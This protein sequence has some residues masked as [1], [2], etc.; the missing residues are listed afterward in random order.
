MT[1]GSA[2]GA[3]PA[4]PG[5][6]VVFEEEFAG[7]SVDTGVWD[8][9]NRRDSFNEEKQ[10]YHPDQVSIVDGSLR[11]TAVDEPRAGKAY[12]SGLVR[13]WQEWS[14]GR[15]EIRAD[16]PTSQGMWPAIWL[17]PRTVNWPTGGE[18]DIMENRGSEPTIVSSAYHWQVD[19]N[20][21]CCDGR[22]FVFREHEATNA[23]GS[24]TNYHAGYHTYAVEWEPNILRFYV[25]GV[26]HMTVNG[27]PLR[28][29]FD[30][31]K[32]L[33][34][35]LAVGGI[36]G[37]DP[38]STTVWPQNFDIDYVHVWQRENG[39]FGLVNG[40][41][42]EADNGLADWTTF[43]DPGGAIR[44]TDADAATGEHALRLSTAGLNGSAGLYQSV[45]IDG[46]ETLRASLASLV[47]SDSGFDAGDNVLL[48]VEFYDQLG[49]S[50][51]SGSFLG[52]NIFEV[53][54]A[55]STFD[56]WTDH[57][58]Y[59][60]A[61]A[62]AV[63]ARYTLIATGSGGGSGAAL[64]DGLALVATDGLPGDADGNGFVSAA[65]YTALRDTGGAGVGLWQSNFGT[66]INTLPAAAVVAATIPEPHTVVLTAT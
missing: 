19:P 65:D 26:R 17:L 10:Y 37:G 61:P 16:L 6:D 51:G 62:D 49:A 54:G 11:L 44:V 8:V 21:P 58:H 40:G 22:R 52:E 20:Q 7:P 33:I 60:A 39:F 25:D 45:A 29:I 64:F 12:Q 18:I 56:A 46:G 24:P 63:E 42:D 1:A 28:P 38:D 55:G 48:K 41:F 23:D 15:F 5:W 50:Y 47:P 34:L 31:P 2:S 14:Y 9:L 30:T 57:L 35:N 53:A 3:A 66:A 32:S 59:V 43:N 36:F 4:I 13:T 27:S